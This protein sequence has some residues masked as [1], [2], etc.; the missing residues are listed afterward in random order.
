MIYKEIDLEKGGMKTDYSKSFKI[1]S[2]LLRLIEIDDGYGFV[3]EQS[4]IK[5]LVDVYV[6][7]NNTQ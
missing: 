4:L 1:L 5:N 7:E 2:F 3:L 6:A